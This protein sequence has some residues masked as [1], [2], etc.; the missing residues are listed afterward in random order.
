MEDTIDS[1]QAAEILRVSTSNLRQL[2]FRKELIP[3]G[4]K[5]RRS[6]FNLA[7][8]QRLDAARLAQTRQQSTPSV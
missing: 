1:N 6:L 5:N 2:V 4:R 3:V 7:D 8:V